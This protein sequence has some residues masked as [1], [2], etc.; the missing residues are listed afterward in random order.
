MSI[1]IPEF[2]LGQLI[3]YSAIFLINGYAGFLV[4]VIFASIALA[5]LIFAGMAELIERSK[6][7]L[8]YFAYMGLAVICPTIILLI[9]LALDPAASSW[10]AE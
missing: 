2:V 5:A 3:I 4:C 1:R 6:V 8:I 10:M 7:P 9:F